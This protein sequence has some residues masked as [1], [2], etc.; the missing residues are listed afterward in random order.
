MVGLRSEGDKTRGL[1]SL[2]SARRFTA[3]A[4]STGTTVGTVWKGKLG[5]KSNQFKTGKRRRTTANSDKG[6]FHLRT[7]SE[8]FPANVNETNNNWKS[9]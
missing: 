2:A 4:E 5:S 3:I 1:L 6:V 8:I 9:L 7:N